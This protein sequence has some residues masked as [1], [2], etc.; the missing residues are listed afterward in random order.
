MIRGSTEFGGGS[1]SEFV[2]PS[3]T[4]F[5]GRNAN[6]SPYVF[7]TATRDQRLDNRGRES[8][9]GN[10]EC[11]GKTNTWEFTSRLPGDDSRRHRAS[12]PMKVGQ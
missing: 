5:R 6:A 9:S 4:M 2:F 10:P 12:G 11:G 8:E 1:P 7:R 3:R